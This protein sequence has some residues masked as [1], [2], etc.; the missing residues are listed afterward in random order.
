[1]DEPSNGYTCELTERD[2]PEGGELITGDQMII[3]QCVKGKTSRRFKL[4]LKLK[5]LYFIQH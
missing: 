4:D 3:A 5:F 2:R 1:M